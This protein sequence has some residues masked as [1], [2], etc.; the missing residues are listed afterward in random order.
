[1]QRGT[2]GNFSKIQNPPPTTPNFLRIVENLSSHE[3]NCFQSIKT[4]FKNLVKCKGGTHRCP[5]LT[6]KGG[7]TRNFSKIQK[8]PQT[9]PNFLE[10]LKTF[11]LIKRITFN[12]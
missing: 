1:M 5:R 3:K 6:N 11:P 9:N 2:T 8:P 12:L 4:G 10:L 7:T